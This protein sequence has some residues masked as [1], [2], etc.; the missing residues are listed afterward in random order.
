MAG[1]PEQN[2]CVKPPTWTEC[3]CGNTDQQSASIIHN[4]R[5]KGLEPTGTRCEEPG[6][7]RGGEERP[8]HR[9]QEAAGADEWRLSRSHPGEDSSASGLGT[10]SVLPDASL[11]EPD[12][13]TTGIQD[14]IQKGSFSPRKHQ[15]VPR[16][17]GFDPRCYVAPGSNT[18][19]DEGLELR[20]GF[21]KKT[22]RP[23]R[24]LDYCL[25][26]PEPTCGCCFPASPAPHAATQ[27]ADT[28]TQ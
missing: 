17:F 12:A 14:G 7:E 27:P 26:K 18:R 19:A 11:P 15:T 4:T 1:K 25:W 9:E 23:S 2:L 13:E 21:K 24:P 10:R 22:R 20:C 16:V 28:R 3:L 5:P 6:P 8:A